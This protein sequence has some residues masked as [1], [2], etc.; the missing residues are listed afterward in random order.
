MVATFAIDCTPESTRLLMSTQ[1][2]AG[3]EAC[4][5]APAYERSNHVNGG[6]KANREKP[7]LSA[8]LIDELDK[9]HTWQ[10]STSATAGFPS[11]LTPHVDANACWWRSV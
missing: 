5:T 9:S 2:L 10:I 8:D 3:G 1:M 11:G 6:L 7:T 4:E